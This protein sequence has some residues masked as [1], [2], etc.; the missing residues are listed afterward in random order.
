MSSTSFNT[1]TGL[2]KCRPMT[3]WG[4]W[5]AIAS[6]MIGIDEVF[7]AR[8]ACGS[9][10]ASSILRKTSSFTPS[11]SATASMTSSQSARSEKS[12]E[13]ERFERTSAPSDSA[14]FFDDTARVSERSIRSSPRSMAATSDSTTTTF[15]PARAAISAMPDPMSPHP[16][17]PIRSIRTSPFRPRQ[18]L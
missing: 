3:C 16:T 14:I 9:L 5:V 4:R 18:S 13:K 17:T 15:A 12:V 6:L 1:G 10:T 11:S 8:M 2:K 7:V